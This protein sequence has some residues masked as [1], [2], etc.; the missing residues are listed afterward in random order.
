VRSANV[1]LKSSSFKYFVENREK[2]EL[3]DH[4]ESPGPIQH[5]GEMSGY[6]PLT[7]SLEER[8]DL[9]IVETIN[10]RLSELKSRCQFGTETRYLQVIDIALKNLYE[11]LSIMENY[12]S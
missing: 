7:I 8:F 4:Y 1:D 9:D 2:W 12:H 11:T 3:T 6:I 5:F 10:K